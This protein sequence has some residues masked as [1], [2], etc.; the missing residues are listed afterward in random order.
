MPPPRPSPSSWR[1]GAWSVTNFTLQTI[2][3]W[4][5][6]ELLEAWLGQSPHC[7]A[8]FDCALGSPLRFLQNIE[9]ET[10]WAQMIVAC[11]SFGQ[12]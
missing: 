3:R 9:W 1:W 11:A 12:N 10:D 8:G 7:V 6:F 2:H 4:H 5:T